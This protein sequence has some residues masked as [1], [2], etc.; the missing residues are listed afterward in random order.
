M[1][2]PGFNE[3]IAFL[4]PNAWKYQR[5][6]MPTSTKERLQM[7]MQTSPS[8]DFRLFYSLY[9]S[10]FQF[11][12]FVLFQD[13]WSDVRMS[14][15]SFFCTICLQCNIGVNSWIRRVKLSLTCSLFSKIWRVQ[16]GAIMMEF[17]ALLHGVIEILLTEKSWNVCL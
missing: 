13:Y 9:A 12:L 6:N 5:F 11:H 17:Y 15:F 8:L 7:V 3:Q 14:G 10:A 1:L 16:C 2:L 4:F